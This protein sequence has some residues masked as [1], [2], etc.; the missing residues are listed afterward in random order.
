MALRW[1]PTHVT[2]PNPRVVPLQLFQ[3]GRELT[4]KVKNNLGLSLCACKEAKLQAGIKPTALRSAI[5]K[6]NSMEFSLISLLL[7]HS[8]TVAIH[9]LSHGPHVTLVM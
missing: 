1:E 4:T 3:S 9:L 2:K 5:D 8:T 6:E 7:I